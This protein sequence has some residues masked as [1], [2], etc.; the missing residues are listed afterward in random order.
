MDAGCR[1]RDACDGKADDDDDAPQLSAYSLAALQEF[2]AEQA[3]HGGGVGRGGSAY[4]VEENWV[5][6][7]VAITTVL[8]HTAK[9]ATEVTAPLSQYI[10]RPS[11]L[12]EGN[13]EHAIAQGGQVVTCV[14]H[15]SWG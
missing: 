5:S 8:Y 15:A 10:P 6:P 4:V 12:H 3:A 2:Y 13:K 11:R 7:A 9:H 1:P 14:R